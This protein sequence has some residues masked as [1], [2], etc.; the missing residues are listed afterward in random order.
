MNELEISIVDANAGNLKREFR[1]VLGAFEEQNNIKLTCTV[2]DWANAWGEIMRIMLYKHGPTMSQVGTTWLG[3]LEATQAIRSF[4][5]LE[6]NQLGGAAAYHPAAWASSISIETGQVTAIPWF[7]DTYVLYYRKDLLEKAGVDETKAFTSLD[8]LAETVAKVSQAGVDI[9][10]AMPAGFSSRAN[11]H[12]L[13]SWIWN[14]GGEFISEDGEHLLLSEP[15]TRK[16]LVGYFSLAR[17]MPKAAQTLTDADC[18]RVFLDG[19]AAI[20]LRN[21]S[22]LYVAEKDP[23]FAV[24]LGRDMDVAAMPG[25]SFVGGSSFVLW[26]HIRPGQETLALALLKQLTSPETQYAYFEQDGFLPARMEALQRLEKRPF[27]GAVAETLK[28]GRSFH[29]IKLWGLVEERLMNA[30]TQIWQALYA[31]PDANVAEEITKVLDPLE[32]RLQLTLSDS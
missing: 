28:R 14:H 6:I 11:L 3:S 22:L 5:P 23:A 19:S 7:V 29:K 31:N 1:S 25:T 24:R 18:Y 13:A 32:R 17:H 26:N 27:Y 20:T 21:T 9:P 10:I 15:K 16:G 12:S 8:A 2:Y 30:V 4:T